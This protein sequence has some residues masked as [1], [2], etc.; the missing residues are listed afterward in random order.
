M[1]HP[2]EL[3]PLDQAAEVLDTRTPAERPEVLLGETL[4]A[5]THPVVVPSDLVV[6]V[7]NQKAPL[8]DLAVLQLIPER[9]TPRRGAVT[10]VED[11]KQEVPLA[12]G[13]TNK[14]V[15]PENPAPTRMRLTTWSIQMV[16]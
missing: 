2:V 15:A 7:P 6:M 8:V 16:L 1:C 10:L 11:T 9:L 12:A 3:D 13:L 5:V 4:G 14:R